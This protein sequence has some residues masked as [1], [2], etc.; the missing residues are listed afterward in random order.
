MGNL[1]H[2]YN[3]N[4][5]NKGVT[6][7]LIVIRGRKGGQCNMAKIYLAVPCQSNV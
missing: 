3:H 5:V 2:A 1:V 4:K 7:D 6:Q